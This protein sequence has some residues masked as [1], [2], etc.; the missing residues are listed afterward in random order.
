MLTELVVL[1]E[2]VVED[3]GRADAAGA[4]ELVLLLLVP[5]ELQITLGGTVTPAVEQSELAK[6]M[7][8]VAHVSTAAFTRSQ[9]SV[10]V[11]SEVEQPLA[12][13][14]DRLWR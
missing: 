4:A 10:L 2:A 12:M 13:Q 5:A 3:T 1:D 7:A 14:H 6:A 9:G 8:S 11:W